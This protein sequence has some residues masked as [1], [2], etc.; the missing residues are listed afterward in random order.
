MATNS[1][2]SAENPTLD[3]LLLSRNPDKLST[4]L[5]D[6]TVILDIE[7]GMYTGL[8]S[9]GT[10]IWKLLEETTGFATLCQKLMKEYEVD[11]ETCRK[12]TLVFLQKLKDTKLI[13]IK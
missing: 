6:E 4:E 9:V 5:D 13:A 10:S 11:E 8:D 2:L 3:N 7:S 1:R 12:D